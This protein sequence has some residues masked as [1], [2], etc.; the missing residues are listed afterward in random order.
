MHEWKLVVFL[1]ILATATLV[2]TGTISFL[3]MTKIQQLEELQ[4]LPP[5]QSAVH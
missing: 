5:V 4:L 2:S 3:G 1:T